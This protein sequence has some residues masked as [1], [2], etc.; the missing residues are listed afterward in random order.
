MSEKI[1]PPSPELDNRASDRHYNP[2]LARLREVLHQNENSSNESNKIVQDLDVGLVSGRL[3]PAEHVDI[4]AA[5]V[6]ATLDQVYQIDTESAPDLN[7]LRDELNESQRV[8][9]ALAR[10]ASTRAETEQ[11]VPELYENTNMLEVVKTLMP[12]INASSTIVYLGSGPDTSLASVYGKSVIHVDADE[13][14]L[15]AMRSAGYRCE[16]ADYDEFATGL[17]DGTQLDLVYSHNS[18]LVPESIL[19]K[20]PSGG[21]V[22]AN[23]W[24]GSANNM[25]AKEDFY[26]VGAVNPEDQSVVSPEV[27]RQGLGEFEIAIDMRSTPMMRTTVDPAEIEEIR[28]LDGVT[29]DSSYKNT[30]AEWVFCKK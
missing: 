2:D 3:Q 9:A 16:L 26:I 29:V 11:S 28:H 27:A 15:A 5:D 22:I 1:T 25:G 24:H 7:A 12:E 6:D 4:A 13:V 19:S 10:I 23:N 20:I 17:E 14:Q 18:G 30:E 21:Y 8:N